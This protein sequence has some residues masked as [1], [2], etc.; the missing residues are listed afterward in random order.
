MSELQAVLFDMDGT[1][2]DT[3][4][5]WMACE[6]RMAEEAGAEWT[7]EDGLSLVGN[8]LVD[9]GVVLKER[10]RLE[11]SAAEIIEDLVAD[12]IEEVKRSGVEWRPGALEL[13]RACNV[14]GIPVALVTMSYRTFAQPI[15]DQMPF[16]SFDLVVTGDEVNRG[17]PHP[18]AYLA[19][20]AALGVEASCCIAIEDSPTGAISA[21]QAGCRVV[22]VPN[23]VA[24]PLTGDMVE[25]RTLSGT[26]I[27]ELASLLAER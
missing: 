20:A 26:T 10:F 27:D 22:V 6:T 3:E 2:C 1:L 8:N 19:A 4:P 21:Y 12:V 15:V 18:E 7:I 5:A 16:G 9:S 24:V 14:A 11:K 17:K 13:V 23:H 25:R